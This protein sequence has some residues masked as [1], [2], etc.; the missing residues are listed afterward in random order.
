MATPRDQ[1][2]TSALLYS[3][4]SNVLRGSARTTERHG[5]RAFHQAGSAAAKVLS[6]PGAGIARRAGQS[7]H[8]FSFGPDRGYEWEGF[9]SCHP[10]VDSER[11]GLKG[12]PLYLAAPGAGE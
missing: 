2:L 4:Q 1:R 12:R 3:N 8:A 6:R 7:P 9:D 10:G 5:A 11:S